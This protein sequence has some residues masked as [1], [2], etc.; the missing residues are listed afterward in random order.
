MDEKNKK[1]KAIWD[2]KNQVVDVT[3]Y[4]DQNKESS[5]ELFDATLQIAD[6]RYK[7]SLIEHFD[8]L[9]D[10]SQAGKIT[11]EA[12]KMQA[13]YFKVFKV[14]K[15]AVVGATGFRS[16]FIK[17]IYALGG[18]KNYKLFKK[19]DEAIAWLNK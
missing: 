5:R 13:K 7:D 17:V 10:V 19:R 1:F 11:T 8:L 6:Q 15:T 4:G 16:A 18:N 3:L 12:Q 2:K 14:R 9:V